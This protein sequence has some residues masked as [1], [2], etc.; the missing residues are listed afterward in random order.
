MK[1]FTWIFKLKENEKHLS[2][3]QTYATKNA[4]IKNLD[5]RE[6]RRKEKHSRKINK[7]IN[8]HNVFSRF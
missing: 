6:Y 3:T 7:Y 8:M 5:R 4:L 1:C 2:N